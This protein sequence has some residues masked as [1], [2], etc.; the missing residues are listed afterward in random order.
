MASMNEKDY[1]AILGVSK[2]AT[3]KEIQ[4]AFQQKAR[5]L[6]PDVNKEPDAEER[7]KEVSEAYAVLSDEEKRAHYDQMRENPYAA[8]G[9]GGSPSSAAYGRGY[10]GYYTGGFGGPFGYSYGYGAQQQRRRS[11][12]AYNPE[13]GADVVVEVELN[14][15]QSRKGA[16]KAVKYTRYEACESCNGSGSINSERSRTCPTCDGAGSIPFDMS[17]LFGVAGQASVPCPE[18]GGSGKVI[19]DPCTA[20]DGTGRR[21]V[22]AEAVVEFP[23]NTH[24]GDEVRVHGA[25][26]AGTNGGSVGD[27]VGRARV[28]SERLEG[29]AQGGFFM[30]GAVL[31]FLVLILLYSGITSVITLICLLLELVGFGMVLSDDAFHR[32]GLWWKRG[33]REIGHGASQGI[34]FAIIALW[35]TS[36]STAMYMRPGMYMY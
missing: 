10:S 18:C 19:A 5:K 9:Y 34:G 35:F 26:N 25:G 36:C 8:A 6:H 4:K 31:P 1:Y 15:D 3:Q 28:A 12:N 23:E 11:R 27:L 22:G 30:M 7:F 20:C 13:A 24:D 17:S 2:D 32:S 33:L 21:R 16:R 14:R 29:R